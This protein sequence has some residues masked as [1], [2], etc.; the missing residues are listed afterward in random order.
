IQTQSFVAR[1]ELQGAIEITQSLLP[2]TEHRVVTGQV[3]EDGCVAGI[4]LELL[5][6]ERN[7]LAVRFHGRGGIAAI[8][9]RI[10]Q[11]APCL[12]VVFIE[13]QSFIETL[14]GIL[15]TM[16]P[17]L[18]YGQIIKRITGRTPRNRFLEGL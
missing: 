18:R 17:E 1:S 3:A 4:D 14:G 7:G 2:V 16:Q 13:L 12:I 15:K 10:A 8:V 11:I 6:G 9:R 5:L